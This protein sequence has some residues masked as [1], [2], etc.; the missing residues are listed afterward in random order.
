M[1]LKLFK[2]PIDEKIDKLLV[3]SRLEEMQ[4]DKKTAKKLY[5]Y[6]KKLIKE[7]IKKG[8]INE[9]QIQE[10]LNHHMKQIMY[11]YI[12]ENLISTREK[13]EKIRIEYEKH[14]E[15]KYN[16]YF[17]FIYVKFL[18]DLSKKYKHTYKNY[19]IN[20]GTNFKQLKKQGIKDKFITQDM[21]ITDNGIEYVKEN[22][23]H[24][25]LS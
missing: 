9:N 21:H 2:N 4:K 11:E 25:N 1:P 5:K 17:K 12:N 23:Y 20:F 16:V 24:Y 15:F 7:D 8:L 19:G 10:R 22:E 14:T 13:N 3:N 6:L 18:H